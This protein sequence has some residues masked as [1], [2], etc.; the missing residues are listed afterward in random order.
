M[1]GAEGCGTEPYQRRLSRLLLYK[2]AVVP[3]WAHAPIPVP[4]SRVFLHRARVD[5]WV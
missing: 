1:I 4:L 2:R 3:S 5:L